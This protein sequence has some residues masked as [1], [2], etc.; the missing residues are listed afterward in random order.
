MAH[1]VK[2][3]DRLINRVRRLRGQLEAVE[4]ALQEEHDCSDVMHALALCRGALTSLTAEVVEGHIRFHLAN[5][6]KDSKRGEAARD[7]IEVVKT[8][9]K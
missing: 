6:D 9:L 7:L 4:R 1:T 2:D 3:K 5:P 8:Y